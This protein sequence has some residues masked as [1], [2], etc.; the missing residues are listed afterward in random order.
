MN[1]LSLLSYG[2]VLGLAVVLS[3]CGGGGGSSGSKPASSPA[4]SSALSSAAVSIQP[5]SS[6]VLSSSSSSIVLSSSSSS[7]LP[8]TTQLKIHG[9]AVADALA[10]GEVI[11]TI[12]AQ[13][14]KTPIND[15]G[16]YQIT[17]NVAD[18]DTAQPFTAIATGAASN[19]WVQMAALYPSIT[20]LRELAGADET[21]DATEYLGVNIS[22][23]TTAEYSLVIGNKLPIA[24]D[25]ERKYTLLQ[26]AANDQL[27]RAAM[28]QRMLV[29]INLDLPEK[30][31]TTLDAFADSEYI[32]GQINIYNAQGNSFS[33]ELDELQQDQRQA[34]VANKPVTGKFLVSS[35]NFGY[36]LDLNENGTGHLLT[37]NAPG[38][39]IWLSGGKYQREASLTWIKKGNDIKITLDAPIVYGNSIGYRSEYLE[40]CEAGASGTWGCPVIMNGMA[41]SLITENEVGKFADVVVDASFVNNAGETVVDFS[42]ENNKANLLDRSQLYKLTKEELDGYEWY[43]NGFRYVFNSDGTASQ[44]NQKNKMETTIHWQLED[45]F[46]TLDG[47]ILMLLPIHP[48]GP[49][50]RAIQLLAESNDPMITEYGIQS[51]MLIKRESVNMAETDWVGRWHRMAAQEDYNFTTANYFIA[52]FDFYSNGVFRDGFETQALGSWNAVENTQLRGLS[53]GKWRFE[54]ELLA[55]NNGQHYVQ[56]CSGADS[57]NFLPTSCII[58]SYVI[59]KTFSGTTFWEYWSHP[60]FQEVDTLRQWRFDGNLD[61]LRQ[62]PDGSWPSFTYE[63]VASNLLFV[64][65]TGKVLEMLSSDKD[66]ISVCEYDAFTSCEQGTSYNLKRSLEMKITVAGGGI[67]EGV[68]NS[69]NS[70]MFAR[71]ENYRLF[72]EASSGYTV[73]ANNIVSNCNGSFGGNYYD[74]PAR[75]TDCEISVTFTPLP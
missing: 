47:D 24:T 43:T 14:Y 73:T 52:A 4:V 37:A 51:V 71:L 16:Q 42:N 58:E 67:V 32:R 22:A 36:L 5:S 21:L 20:K 60:L 49:G 70:H 33:A 23:M 72:L 9:M 69:T 11:F 15:Q 65:D 26:I 54:Y 62:L 55:I 61:F 18:A 30:Y 28:L 44:V 39:V 50:F 29:D 34:K 31:K 46:L 13:T 45:G 1:K 74:I 19:A 10:G 27:K 53:N 17:L 41:I 35:E 3:G 66:S 7:S 2:V 68:E 8:A 6:S 57:E 25:V 12:G 63:K 48:S 38:F 64:R 56:Y 75:E 59:D 40:Q